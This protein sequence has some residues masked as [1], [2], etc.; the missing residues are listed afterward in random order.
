M[1]RIIICSDGTWD[2]PGNTDHGKVVR[3]NVQKI[4][5]VIA[6][7]DGDIKQIKHYDDG[8]GATGYYLKRVINGV[9]GGGLDGN[10]IDAYKF[11]VWNYE[12]GDEL[13]LFGFSRGAYTARSLAGLIRKCGILK[14]QDLCIIQEAYDFYRDRSD[15]SMPGK[16][17]SENFIA[18]NSYPNPSIKFIGVWDTVGALGIPLS[19]FQLWNKEKYKFHDLALSSII[20]HAYQAMA[21]DEER[22]LFDVNLWKRSEN[23]TIN[24]VDQ[25]VEQRWFAGVHCDVGGGYQEEQLSDLTLLWMIEKAKF[26]ELAIDMSMAV[27]NKKFSVFLS[28][29]PSGKQHNSRTPI[30]WLSGTIMRKIGQLQGFN[31][32]IDKSVFE[33][34]CLCDF[35]KPKNVEEGIER[36]VCKCSN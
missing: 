19:I 22:E 33:R 24:K 10:I 25:F 9:T 8:V 14:N 20:K 13:Y 15:D 18:K 7:S 28:P 2:K 3:S 36:G 17:L 35:Y 12:E 27:T 6:K 29:S 21:I 11:I 1:K 23:A 34:M 5:Q 32:C 4:F 30:Y 31:E 26:A 16:L